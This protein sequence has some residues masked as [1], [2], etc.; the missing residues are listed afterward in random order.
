MMPGMDG[1]TFR[2]HQ[3][4][5]PALAPIPVVLMSASHTLLAAQ[6]A[7]QPSAALAKPFGIDELSA[8]IR[9]CTRA[10]VA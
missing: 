1:W 2:E 6:A 8:A 3:R 9:G 4:S 5:T 7:L 10:R